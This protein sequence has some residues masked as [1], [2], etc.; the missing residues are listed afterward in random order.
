MKILKMNKKVYELESG[1]VITGEK[2]LKAMRILGIKLRE[3]EI[4]ETNFILEGDERLLPLYGNDYYSDDKNTV[5][6]NKMGNKKF[7][8]KIE[9]NDD[10]PNIAQFKIFLD[11]CVIFDVGDSLPEIFRVQNIISKNGKKY[12]VIVPEIKNN[13]GYFI[14]AIVSLNTK[15]HSVGAVGSY[16]LSAETPKE[17][18]KYYRGGI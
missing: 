7:P 9:T 14:D 16:Y 8:Y 6:T 17:M 10:K 1:E 13:Y 4:I 3:R 12:A 11:D 2:T 15:K 5:V 18:E